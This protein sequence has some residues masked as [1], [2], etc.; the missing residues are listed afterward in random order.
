MYSIAEF[1]R[2]IGVSVPT[3]RLWHSKGKL[4]PESITA[5]GQRRYSE[6]QV[7]EYLTAHKIDI[8]YCNESEHS[9]M[10]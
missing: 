4:V 2:Q 7:K 5:G 8:A 3:L 9:L 6:A 1:S 10:C